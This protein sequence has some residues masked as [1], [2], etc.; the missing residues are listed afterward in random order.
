MKWIAD[1][2]GRLPKRPYYEAVEIEHRC[3]TIIQEFCT[4]RHGRVSF[5][6]DTNDL[7]VLIEEHADLDSMADLSDE[8]ADVEGLTQFGP[9]PLVRIS[10]TLWEPYRE[11]RLRTTLTHEL[12]H[13]IFHNSLWTSVQNQMQFD[14]QPVSIMNPRCNR[15]AILDN[16]VHRLDGV[17]SRLCLWSVIDASHGRTSIGAIN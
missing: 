15:D 8:G 14:F 12:G 10:S 6:L 2:T 7:T 17:A 1:N 5:P 11:N 13:V 16:G 4:R 3:E 9:K